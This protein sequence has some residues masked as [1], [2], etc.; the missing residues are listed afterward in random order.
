MT[1]SFAEVAVLN[2]EQSMNHISLEKRQAYIDGMQSQPQFKMQCS[3]APD[4]I[5][6]VGRNKSTF[7]NTVNYTYTS[8]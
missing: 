6:A 5:Y 8:S 4:P 1:L 7:C 3:Q 2:T